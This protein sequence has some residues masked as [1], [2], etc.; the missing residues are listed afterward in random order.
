M[1][2]PSSLIDKKIRVL[3]GPIITGRI[4]PECL[5]KVEV[6]YLHYELSAISNR[7]KTSHTVKHLV[8]IIEALKQDVVA[9]RAH[10]E[11]TNKQDEE[12]L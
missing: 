2:I 12:A 1:K 6:N 11:W 10:I 9:L 3:N 5:E 8:S 7:Y 4:N